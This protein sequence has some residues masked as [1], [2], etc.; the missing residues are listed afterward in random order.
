MMNTQI[1]AVLFDMD[2]VIFDSEI[3][4]IE[5]WKDIAEKYGFKPMM[6]SDMFFRIAGKGEYYHKKKIP[7]PV[8]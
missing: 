1:Q 4:V 2:G 5:C 3:K 6:W 8:H 7:R